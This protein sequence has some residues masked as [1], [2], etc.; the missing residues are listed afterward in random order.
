MPT[1]LP[2]SIDIGTNNHPFVSKDEKIDLRTPNPNWTFE[3]AHFT[4]NGPKTVK[5]ISARLPASLESLKD[6]LSKGLGNIGKVIF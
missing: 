5:F 4:M 3:S 2:L 6:G 1:S